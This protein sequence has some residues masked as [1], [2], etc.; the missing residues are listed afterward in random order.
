M[1]EGI[2]IK[3]MFD[4]GMCFCSM[5][6]TIHVYIYILRFKLDHINERQKT[7]SLVVLYSDSI[8]IFVQERLTLNQGHIFRSRLW[9]ITANTVQQNQ[10]AK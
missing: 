7:I 5:V 2:Y 1:K 9:L 6:W 3:W 8:F 10:E 4:V